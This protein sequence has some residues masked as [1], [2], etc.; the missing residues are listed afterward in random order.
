[1]KSLIFT[2]FFSMTLTGIVFS[3][4]RTPRPQLESSPNIN[5]GGSV[6][7][8]LS[9]PE[10]FVQGEMFGPCVN[11]SNVQ[12]TFP[13]GKLSNSIGMWSD[14]LNH[15]GIDEGMIISTGYAL[16][17]I[18][19]VSDFASNDLIGAG[20][21]NLT[22]LCGVTTYDAV[23]I[24]FDFVPLADSIV[25]F[26]FVFGSEEYPEYV[27]TGY[28]DVFAFYVTGTGY[29]G[30]ENVAII[31]GTNIPIAIDNINSGSYSQYF[32]DN[33]AING[34][35]WVYDGYTT[36]FSLSIPVVALE[37]YHF[38]A[39]I[40][41]AGDGIYDSGV[42]LRTGSFA[43]NIIAP[44]PSFT[45]EVNGNAVTFTNTTTNGMNYSWD[46]GDGT[47]STEE[48][49]VHTY[50]GAGPYTLKLTAA[51][52]CY[53]E[54]IEVVMDLATQAGTFPVQEVMLHSMNQQGLYN[55]SGLTGK[56]S[57][58][59]CDI[60]GKTI[61]FQLNGTM[62]VIDLSNFQSGVYILNVDG[63]SFKLIRP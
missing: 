60:T 12:V 47:F 55:L 31:P 53:S 2:F 27:N 26:E 22:A 42:V 16:S 57:I 56:E 18:G 37:S 41:D 25:P 4:V 63:K 11:I 7:T 46:F 28:N 5:K 32:I 6:V 13:A 44:A 38:K 20:D 58:R 39:V 51:N 15:I 48:N 33:Q 36:V 14:S 8:L 30:A 10:S 19:T 9:D 23:S 61:Q 50:A 52:H 24:E 34:S 3:Q 29:T 43:G 35:F 49:P 21:T 17:A 59:L 45:Y 1:M 62:A 54:E 40:A